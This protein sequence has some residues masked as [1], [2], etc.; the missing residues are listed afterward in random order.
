MV[1][2]NCAAIPEGMVESELFGHERG[3]FTSAVERRVGRFELAQNGTLFLDEIGELSLGVQAKLLRVLQSGEFERVGG[4]KTIASNARIVAATNRDLA[5]S[6]ASGAF[7]ADLFYRLNVFPIGVPTLAERREDIPLLAQAF[8]EQFARRMGKHLTGFAPS[9]L[10][11]LCRREWPGNVRELKH[12]IERAVILCDG[13]LLEIEEEAETRSPASV[14][15]Q[16]AAAI[17]TLEE[18][19]DAHIRSA[20]ERTGGIIEGPRGAAALLGLKASTL[21]FRMKRQGIR[22]PGEA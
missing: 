1:K 2:L 13:P 3:A 8:M 4:A 22:R 19:Q 20:L 16:P 17:A 21:R 6:L 18:L 7:R 12:V 9:A 5:R 10:E 14:L 15:A 11:Q